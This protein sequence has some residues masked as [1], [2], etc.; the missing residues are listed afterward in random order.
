MLLG[1]SLL[2]FLQE[3]KMEIPVLNCH[4]LLC[5]LLYGPHSHS[6]HH[7]GHCLCFLHPELKTY[8]SSWWDENFKKIIAWF[9]Q[10]VATS[11]A[12]IKSQGLGISPGYYECSPFVVFTRQLQILVTTLHQPPFS[13]TFTLSV[14]CIH[15]YIVLF[16]FIHSWPFKIIFIEMYCIINNLVSSLSYASYMSLRLGWSGQPHPTY[17]HK[18]IDW[19]IDVACLS[20]ISY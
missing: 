17:W 4:F 13:L 10:T 20:V 9:G 8:I 6:Q 3:L 18:Y 5:L 11:R 16:V 7:F 14:G 1:F 15:R 12:V 2:S 19:L